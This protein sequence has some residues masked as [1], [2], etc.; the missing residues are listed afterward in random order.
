MNMNSVDKNEIKLLFDI[1]K[2]IIYPLRLKFGIIICVLRK[3]N[4]MLGRYVNTYLY[5]LI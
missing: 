5:L 4:I 2:H 3:Y 1:L